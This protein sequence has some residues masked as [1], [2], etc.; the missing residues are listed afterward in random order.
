MV[1]VLID[2]DVILDFYFDRLPFSQDASKIIAL[3]ETQKFNGYITP[4]IIS[5][6]YYLLKKQS[7]HKKVIEIIKNLLLIIDVVS[8]E[9]SVVVKA[10]NSEFKDFENALKHFSA[11]KASTIEIIITQ[12]IKDYK[13][14][15]LS[16]MTP[17]IFIKGFIE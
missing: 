14:S 15:Q 5:N 12:N 4:L 3:C 1:N 8:I 11:V 6:V 9:K 17:S 7:N 16:V 13:L 2:S 10:L